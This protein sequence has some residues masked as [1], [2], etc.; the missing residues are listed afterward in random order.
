MR[1][2]KLYEHF[3]VKNVTED[4]VI[5]CI[6]GGGYVYATVIKDF[7]G[8]D[9]EEPLKAVSIDEDGLVTIE[10]DGKEYETEL[11]NIEK[12]DIPESRNETY[13]VAPNQNW[14]DDKESKKTYREYAELITKKLNYFNSKWI[15]VDTFRIIKCVDNTFPNE[16]YELDPKYCDYILE[17]LDIT[18]EIYD[19]ILFVIQ[20]AKDD[21]IQDINIELKMAKPVGLYEESEAVDIWVNEEAVFDI[22]IE[23]SGNLRTT[24]KVF[25][26]ILSKLDTMGKANCDITFKKDTFYFCIVFTTG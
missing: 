11:K 6:K 4:D 5:N 7:P 23:N 22:I 9:P 1:Y 20:D 15:T 24:D 19:D 3:K 2:L 13:K 8:N 26:Q 18:K 17:N 10:Y 14:L 25:N 12:I 21:S 16:K